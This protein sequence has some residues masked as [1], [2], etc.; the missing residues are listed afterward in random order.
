MKHYTAFN[1][2]DYLLIIQIQFHSAASGTVA[3]CRLLFH[4]LR[5]S[6]GQDQGAIE[7]ELKIGDYSIPTVC[8]DAVLTP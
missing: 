2:G 8:T 7:K 6:R 5:I 4:E 1:K 3:S